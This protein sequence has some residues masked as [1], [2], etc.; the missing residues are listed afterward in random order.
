MFYFLLFLG[1]ITIV[2]WK[3]SDFYNKIIDGIKS[4]IKVEYELINLNGDK[5]NGLKIIKNLNSDAILTIGEIP[6][7]LCVQLDIKKPVVFSGVYNPER[8]LKEENKNITGVSLNVEYSE[9][10]ELIENALPFVKKIFIPYSDTSYINNLKWKDWKIILQK[11]NK[12]EEI[13]DVLQNAKDCDLIMIIPDPL[14]IS[15]DVLSSILIFGIKNKKPVFAPSEKI[16]KSGALFGISSDYYNNGKIAA[17]IMNKVIKDKEL[18]KIMKM[19]EF[20][21][22]INMETLN[23]IEIKMNESVIKNAEKY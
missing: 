21:T 6:L 11:V 19:K 14:I 13:N 18:P 10:F 20:K 12:K 2:Q 23:N 8:I 3:D 15:Q 1:K 22:Y 17:E 4:E 9:Q 7:M 16:V 5:E